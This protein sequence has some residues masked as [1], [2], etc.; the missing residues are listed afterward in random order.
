MTLQRMGTCCRQHVHPDFL[1]LLVM[2]PGNGLGPPSG[3]SDKPCRAGQETS[4]AAALDSSRLLVRSSG[5]P[6]VALYSFLDIVIH[7]GLQVC[8]QPP[9]MGSEW[10]PSLPIQQ[11]FHSRLWLDPVCI[12]QPCHGWQS[13]AEGR[14][15]VLGSCLA[16]SAV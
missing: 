15:V 9:G 10:G 11:D 5:T 13:R 6:S 16:F 14:A 2:A 4:L 8:F 3:R 7:Q 1:W 12:E